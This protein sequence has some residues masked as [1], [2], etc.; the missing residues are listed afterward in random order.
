MSI[1]EFFNSSDFGYQR[2]NFGKSRGKTRGNSINLSLRHSFN[3]ISL[4]KT[5][6]ETCYMPPCTLQSMNNA[7][8]QISPKLG[9]L[10]I[11]GLYP[12]LGCAGPT[13]RKWLIHMP[14]IYKYMGIWIINHLTIYDHK[15]S[16]FLVIPDI[17]GAIP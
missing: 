9:T 14:H 8:K 15:P 1:R 16:V 10:K 5:L 2:I 13:N 3:L 4:R 6:G 12:P 17:S 11:R 7:T